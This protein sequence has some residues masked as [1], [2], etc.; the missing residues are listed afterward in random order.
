MVSL[1]IS[2]LF[3]NVP[4]QQTIQIILDKIFT[5]DDILF[6]G[7]SKANFKKLLELAVLDTAFIFNDDL[8]IQTDGLSMGSPLGPVFANIFM[9]WLEEQLLDNCPLAYLPLFYCRYVDDTF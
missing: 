7:F 8:F 6:N 2:S 4:V 9:C 5:A 1:D 3:T